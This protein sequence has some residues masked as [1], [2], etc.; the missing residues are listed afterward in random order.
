MIALSRVDSRLVHG[1]V[2]EA[3]LPFT[4]ADR[5][6]V[7]DDAAA[8]DAIARAA[9]GLALPPKVQLKVE[10]LSDVDFAALSS[11]PARTMVLFR[12]VATLLAAR[13]RGYSPASVNL[14][15]VHAGP[16]RAAVS[17]SV[18]LSP[19]EVALLG[20]LKRGGAVVAAQAIPQDAPIPVG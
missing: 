1:Q 13:A 9:M 11:D 6:L 7:V 14:G 16:G 20:E 2:I 8:S 15:N 12:D 10:K 17:R 19:D 18:F 3:W 4:K 5:I